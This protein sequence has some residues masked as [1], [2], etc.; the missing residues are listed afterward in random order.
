MY[1]FIY[2]YTILH[3]P[4]SSR[5][6]A[7]RTSRRPAVKRYQVICYSIITIISIMRVYMYMYTYVYIYIYTHLYHNND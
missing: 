5:R 7:R 4:R 2:I 6:R 1:M 3:C